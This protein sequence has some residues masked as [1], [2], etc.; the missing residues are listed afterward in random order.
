MY[1]PASTADRGRFSQGVAIDHT[2]DGRAGFSDGSA[3]C[4][5]AR[6]AFG[7]GHVWTAPDSA[8]Q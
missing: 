7:D 8:G 5:V 1:N 3:S 2:F 6:I 4:A